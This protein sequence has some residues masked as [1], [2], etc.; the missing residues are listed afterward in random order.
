MRL[1][2][3]VLLGLILLL[4]VVAAGGY[5]YFRTSLPQVAGTVSVQGLTAPVQIVR[6]RNAVPHIYARSIPD[7]YYALGYAHAQ[8]RLWQM[9]MNRRVAAGR[10]SEVVGAQT[11]VLETDKM[12]RILGFRHLAEM[13]AQ[14]LTGFVKQVHD[15]Y[16][17][18]V[19]AFL[20][21]PDG[22][23]PPEFALAR[24][25]PEPWSVADTL[26]WHR[27]MAL[28]LSGNMFGE[29]TRYRL[30]QKV[31][32]EKLRQFYPPYPG[33]E[34]VSLGA[35]PALPD[36]GGEVDMARLAALL[37]DTY[38]V[39]SNNWV[40]DGRRTASGK[41]LLANDPHLGLTSPAIW[42]FAHLSAPG[43][44]VAGATFPGVPGVVIGRNDRIAWGVT[45]TGPDT[46][47]LFIERVD[48]ANPGRYITPDGTQPFSER[49]E[50]IR[51][52]GADS[53][54][55]L[56]RGTRHGPVVSDLARFKAEAGH[57]VALQWTALD[58][59]DRTG[60]AVESLSRVRNWTGFVDAMRIY[61][62]PMQNFVYGDIEGNI[63][64]IAPGRIPV[65]RPDNEIRG[66]YPSPGWDA[67]YD[68]TGY[69][70]FDDLPR[71]LNPASGKV[72]T[73][74]HKIVP[75]DYPYFLTSE[76]HEPYR[77][78]RIEQLL[79]ARP[80]HTLES[81]RALQGDVVSLQVRELL[82]LL[83]AVPATDPNA[84]AVRELMLRWNGSMDA[85]RPE[86]LIYAA[87]ARAFSRALFADELGDMYRGQGRLRPLFLRNVMTDTDGAAQWCDNV[88]TPATETCAELVARALVTALDE[89]RTSQ[90]NE[91]ARWR[92]GGPH[93]AVFE[94]RPLGQVPVLRD[95][96]DVRVQTPGDGYT[97]NVG[98]FRPAATRDPFANVH[99]ASLRVIFDLDD[100]DR[101][102]FMFAPGQS[103]NILS[104]H[105]RDLAQ[106]W[107]AVDYLTMTMRRADIE[108]GAKGTLTLEPKTTP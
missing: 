44:E 61:G 97:V 27:M 13:Q 24:V 26:T 29:V 75:D 79:A 1:A 90:G 37:P 45:N 70:P 96:F 21:N 56:V 53:V 31:S 69:I 73:A 87:W 99:A 80:V 12:F 92:W 94:H 85:D 50:V 64:F 103:G 57:V 60:E 62:A 54:E 8:D 65:R 49:R 52:R 9:E 17:A 16:A 68:W 40:V 93:S 100:L 67:K 25:T 77:A 72:V 106:P 11:E 20:A 51:I 6:D 46:Q 83:L 19:N 3:R 104:P 58:P 91:V 63:G 15:A 59:D 78:A 74:N 36:L 43:M 82:P 105:Y 34:P 39:G 28:S 102:Q 5:F 22:A 98:H 76:W 30:A 48:P 38:G 23:L 41:P 14:K 10:L 88:D 4:V 84:I 7:A 66:L 86:P 18:G 32:P 101:S 81:F 89:L 95:L 71:T 2:L 42:Y 107:S 35:A 55:L 47:D 33:G 108:T